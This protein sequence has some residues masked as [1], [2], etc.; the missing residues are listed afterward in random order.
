MQSPMLHSRHVAPLS[1]DCLQR[2]MGFI[3]NP[4]GYEG[5]LEEVNGQRAYAHGNPDD[6]VNLGSTLCL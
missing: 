3:T 6:I 4:V 5:L 2:S 1:P